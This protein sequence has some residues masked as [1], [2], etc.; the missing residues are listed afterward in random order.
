[1]EFRLPERSGDYEYST[2][3]S[4]LKRVGDRVEAGEPLV[5][6][7]TDK[8]TRGGRGA[9]QRHDR[10]HPR[11]GG[12]RGEGRH[13]ARDHRGGA[14]RGRLDRSRAPSSSSS[15]CC[16][17]SA[18]APSRRRAMELFQEKLIRGSVHPYTGME[19]IAVG[20]CSA[21]GE[22]D[23]I[24]STHR[25]HGHSHREGP[26][27]EADDGRD[28]RPRHRL[29]RRQGRQHAHHRDAPRHARRRRDRRRLGRDRDRRGVRPAPAGE[30]RRGR[31]VL[32]R[33]RRRTRASSTRRRTW[34]RSSPRR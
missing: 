2:I 29:L 14:S 19:A 1:M 25:G 13:R 11:R 7:E 10:R 17:C 16:R 26:R 31:L 8:A 27:P 4:W 28:H 34:P 12:R 5:E 15:A 24:T 33:R 21:L 18:S 23:Y 6:I 30:G 32:R 9:G 22:Q 3:Q 20:V